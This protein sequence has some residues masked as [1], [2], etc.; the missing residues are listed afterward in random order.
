MLQRK[1]IIFLGGILF[2]LVTAAVILLTT[3]ELAYETLP[4]PVR[5]AYLSLA[6]RLAFSDLRPASRFMREAHRATQLRPTD[7]RSPYNFQYFTQDIAVMDRDSLRCEACHGSMVES[8]GGKPKF[9]IHRK[10]LTAPMIKFH[11]VDCHKRVDLGRRSPERATIK[12]DRTQC[13]KCHESE[14]GSPAEARGGG[15]LGDADVPEIYLI[16]NH[17][18][19]K[20]SGKSWPAGRHGKVAARIGEQKCRRCHLPGSEL[21]FCDDCHGRNGVKAL[22]R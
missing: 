10:M 3:S 6:F 22:R 1:K 12:V 11:C 20:K 15:R 5:R 7:K 21:D 17:G 18:I 4:R 19:D 13:V 8:E 16:S 9:P 2:L 14:A